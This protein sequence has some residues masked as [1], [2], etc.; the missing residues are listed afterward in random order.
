MRRA[1]I[2]NQQHLLLRMETILLIEECCGL[3]LDFR[4]DYF[5][6]A[7]LSILTVFVNN[8]DGFWAKWTAG[9]MISMIISILPVLGSFRTFDYPCTP[10]TAPP[11]YMPPSARP[12]PIYAR[13]SESVLSYLSIL[14]SLS[15]SLLSEEFCKIM[16]GRLIIHSEVAL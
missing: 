4:S 16:K 14:R 6:G 1:T 3:T 9:L 8:L 2:I 7:R 12:P 5:K 11:I 13:L 10:S 15:Q